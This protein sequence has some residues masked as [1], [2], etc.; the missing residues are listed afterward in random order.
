MDKYKYRA[1]N[2]SGYPVRGVISASSEADLYNQLKNANLELVACSP[3][4]ASGKA[5][6]LSG[7]GRKKVVLRDLIQIFVQL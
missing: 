7:F 6:F 2:T 3:I 5:S 4:S 1:L